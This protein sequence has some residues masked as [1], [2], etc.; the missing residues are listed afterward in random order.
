MK[1]D[2]W[3][4]FMIAL[5][6]ALIVFCLQEIWRSPA[7]LS[8]ARYLLSIG[9]AVLVIVLKVRALRQAAAGR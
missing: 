6:G 7:P 4:R 8:E 3:D 5:M 2:L 9:I 1:R